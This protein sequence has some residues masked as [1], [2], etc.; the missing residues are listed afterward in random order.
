MREWEN[1]VGRSE[2]K[3]VTAGRLRAHRDDMRARGLRLA[4]IWVHDRSAPEFVAEARRQSALVAA[5]PHEADD[6]AFVE[7]ASDFADWK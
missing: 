1:E 5:S 6:Q 4:R 2:H 7:A 3:K